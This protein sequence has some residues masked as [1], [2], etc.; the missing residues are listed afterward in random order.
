MASPDLICDECG[1]LLYTPGS[2]STPVDIANTSRLTAKQKSDLNIVCSSNTCPSR[3]VPEGFAGTVED[4]Q[5]EERLEQLGDSGTIDP[6]IIMGDQQPQLPNYD[7]VPQQDQH[8]EQQGVNNELELQLQSLFQPP[9]RVDGKHVH[10]GVNPCRFCYRNAMYCHWAPGADSCTQCQSK[11]IC[12][13]YL[14]GA[15]PEGHWKKWS[16][17]NYAAPFTI[18]AS[19]IRKLRKG[20]DILEYNVKYAAKGGKARWE[21]AE[22]LKDFPWM[23]KKFHHDMPQMP[24][25]E[26]WLVEEEGDDF[27]YGSSDHISL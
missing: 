1:T 25:P 6:R 11:R 10:K 4:I 23:L 15:Q 16:I 13:K 24:G 27:F 5:M 20:G 9:Q 2:T 17:E 19:R 8:H 14:G 12:N 26:D 7:Q 18:N 22:N 21:L 3:S